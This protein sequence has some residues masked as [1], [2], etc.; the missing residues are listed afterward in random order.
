MARGLTRIDR[1]VI[2]ESIGPVF[3][4]FM[5]STFILLIRAFFE[6]AEA[7]IHRGLPTPT[8]LKLLALLAGGAA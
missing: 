7:I 4:G 1:Y 2:T 6:L 8:V 3:L 5:V